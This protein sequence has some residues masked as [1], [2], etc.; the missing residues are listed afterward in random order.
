MFM[1]SEKKVCQYPVLK[2]YF[3]ES[4]FPEVVEHLKNCNTCLD[5]V[6]D[7]DKTLLFSSPANR[8][9]DKVEDENELSL[10]I[11]QFNAGKN[12]SPQLI[13]QTDISETTI[14]GLH[15]F[16]DSYSRGHNLQTPDFLRKIVTNE[17]EKTVSRGIEQI[18]IKISG[19]LKIVANYVENIKI[20]PEENMQLAFR[21]GIDKTQENNQGSI[22][23]V[24]ILEDGPVNYNVIKDGPDSVMMTMSFEEKANKPDSINIRSL[25]QVVLSQRLNQNYAYFPKLKEGNYCVEFKYRSRVES[26]SLPILIV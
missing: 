18:I 8:L 14:K 21:S 16:I 20:I 17:F 7:F 19:G 24:Q 12:Q 23:F 26:F 25:N 6:L 9:S 22:N 15:K 1:K 13:D 4:D 5:K 10:R 3:S 2:K 11:D